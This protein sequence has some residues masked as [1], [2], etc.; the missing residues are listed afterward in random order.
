MQ[1]NN[2]FKESTLNDHVK[3]VPILDFVLGGYYKK[4][5]RKDCKGGKDGWSTLLDKLQGWYPY[6]DLFQ[7]NA[8][9]EIAGYIVPLF[10]S[11]AEYLLTCCPNKPQSTEN[12]ESE[13]DNNTN[14]MLATKLNEELKSTKV[15]F[16]PDCLTYEDERLGF[17]E[18][19]SQVISGK[20]VVMVST[21]ES[22]FMKD[23]AELLKKKGAAKVICI[24]AG[25]FFGVNEE[26]HKV[27]NSDRD[28]RTKRNFDLYKQTRVYPIIKE[29]FQNFVAV[30]GSFTKDATAKSRWDKFCEKQTEIDSNHS[31]ASFFVTT[32]TGP[33]TTIVTAAQVQ[34]DI[35]KKEE[36]R[37][38]KKSA[39][40]KRNRS[41]GGG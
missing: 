34:A 26:G 1:E 30:M 17:D 23:A 22:R 12:S 32:T 39:T 36:K 2:I 8:A 27:Y 41:K 35:E 13:R 19:H 37:G 15:R 24:A 33:S 18:N 38:A 21:L 4:D 29:N 7:D 11:N 40:H 28:I 31:I 6:N 10:N 25:R 5:L 20:V 9:E 14:L 3:K 16:V